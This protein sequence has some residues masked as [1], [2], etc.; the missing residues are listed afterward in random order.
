[1][2]VW[3]AFESDSD[4]GAQGTASSSLRDSSKARANRARVAKMASGGSFNGR[5]GAAGR[6]H[7]CGAVAN[8]TAA[9]GLRETALPECGNDRLWRQLVRDRLT[10]L[11]AKS[12]RYGAPRSV[13]GL[14]VLSSCKMPSP[15]S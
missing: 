5:I 1:H 4:L 3:T 15:R 10:Y 12:K 13:P 7:L 6:C 2:E 11:S 14:N 9:A 8:P